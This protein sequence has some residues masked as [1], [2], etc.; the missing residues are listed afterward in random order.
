MR[1]G[2]KWTIDVA[3]DPDT[4]AIITFYP[5]KTIFNGHDIEDDYSLLMSALN[6]AMALDDD[7]YYD[8]E[9]DYGDD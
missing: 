8:D 9:E 2:S 1:Y 3:R 4:G 5:R 7:Y 6:V